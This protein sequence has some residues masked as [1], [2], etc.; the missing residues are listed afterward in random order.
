MGKANEQI[1]VAI[2]SLP[3]KPAYLF[4]DT[5]MWDD[6]SLK[7][8]GFDSNHYDVARK[9][10]IPLLWYAEAVKDSGHLWLIPGKGG[11]LGHPSCFPGHQILASVMSGVIHNEMKDVC[12]HGVQGTDVKLDFV[13]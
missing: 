3:Q 11:G 6:E 12:M 2:A 8:K 5:P 10:Q 7:L 1:Y 13:Q 9:H 4:F